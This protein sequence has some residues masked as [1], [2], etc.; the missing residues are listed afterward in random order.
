MPFPLSGHI[1]NRCVVSCTTVSFTIFKGARLFLAK[2]PRKRPNI[3]VTGTPGVG[4][5][6]FCE[7]L[8]EELGFEHLNISNIIRDEVLYHEWDDELNCSVFDE[9]RVGDWLEDKLKSGGFVVDFHSCDF[10]GNWFSVVVVLRARTEV[11]FDRL[12]A[13]NYSDRKIEENMQCE[14]FQVPLDEAVETFG[15]EAI[16]ELQSNSVDD[17]TENIKAVTTALLKDGIC[18]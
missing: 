16:L 7:Q 4:K 6:T 3:L 10:M 14:I 15:E 17:I 9:D 2:M 1:C 5:T 11:L 18:N 12:K 8:A 13:R